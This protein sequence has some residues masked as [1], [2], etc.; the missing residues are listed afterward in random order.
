MAP[1]YWVMDTRRLE[2][3]YWLYFQ[4]SKCS[5]KFALTSSPLIFIEG[6]GTNHPVTRR[7]VSEERRSRYKTSFALKTVHENKSELQVY[8]IL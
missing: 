6:T 8:E 7:H 5:R 3:N 1:Y 2:T 4:E